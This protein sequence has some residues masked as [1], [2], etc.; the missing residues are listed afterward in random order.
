MLWNP[1]VVKIERSRHDEGFLKM[2]ME[3]GKL[4]RLGGFALFDKFNR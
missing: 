1:D 4:R 2:L 3:N